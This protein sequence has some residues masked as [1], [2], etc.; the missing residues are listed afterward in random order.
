MKMLIM[1]GIAGLLTVRSPA[2]GTFLWGNASAPTR[3]Y[4]LDGPLAGPGILGQMLAGPNPDSLSPVGVAMDHLPDGRVL[5]PGIVSVPDVPC[6]ETAYFQFVAWDGRVWGNDLALVPDGQ[7]GRTDVVP[8]TLS[9]EN[10]P[11]CSG[12]PTFAPRFTRP[13]VVPPVPEPSIGLL[14]GLGAFWTLPLRTRRRGRY[15]KGVGS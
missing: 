8:L 11:N 9:G 14:L 13:A 4:R 12:F 10:D 2:Q 6:L 15:R 3:L 7:L 5:S 1:L